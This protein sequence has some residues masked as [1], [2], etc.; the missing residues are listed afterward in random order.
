MGQT[1]PMGTGTGQDGA[2]VAWDPARGTHGPGARDG[3]ALHG[4]RAVRLSVCQSPVATRAVPLC[5]PITTDNLFNTPLVMSV[6]L[7]KNVFQYLSPIL[8]MGTLALSFI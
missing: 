1:A 3:P 2:R 7:A 4:A 8:P 6:S 5:A